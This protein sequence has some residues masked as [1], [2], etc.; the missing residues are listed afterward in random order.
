LLTH[1][2]ARL[3]YLLLTQRNVLL[4]S[5]ELLD[6]L[7]NVTNR[8]KFQRYFSAEDVAELLEIIRERADF[9]TVSSRVEICRDVKD[10]FLLALAL[11][12]KADFLLTGDRD[13]LALTHI[14]PTRIITIAHY[15]SQN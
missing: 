9:I 5:Q 2:Y 3:D 15:L 10:N 12:G 11:D 1:N 7:L 14:G 4:F 6:E 8:P 13:L